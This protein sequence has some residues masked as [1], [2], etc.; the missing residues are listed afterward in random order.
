M[1]RKIR[2]L[3]ATSLVLG[4]VSACSSPTTPPYPE[5]DDDELPDREPGSGGQAGL[6][7]IVEGGPVLI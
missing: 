2:M 1:Y 5:E 7:L 4:L 3:L 6:N